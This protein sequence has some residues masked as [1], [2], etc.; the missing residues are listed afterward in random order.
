MVDC[1]D[2]GV[3]MV[4]TMYLRFDRVGGHTR[5][6]MASMPIIPEAMLDRED[7]NSNI[8][9]NTKSNLKEQM[10]KNKKISLERVLHEFSNV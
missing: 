1:F 8:L 9:F 4:V 5:M 6:I 2:Q 3:R 7:Q 10:Q